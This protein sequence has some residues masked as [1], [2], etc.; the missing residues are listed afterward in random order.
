MVVESGETGV[1]SQV[2]VQDIQTGSVSEVRSGAIL[3]K[4]TDWTLIS[5][6]SSLLVIIQVISKSPTSSLL[7]AYSS[8]LSPSSPGEVASRVTA[9]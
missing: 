8:S 7:R 6:L 4:V 3:P 5:E 1:P 2:A 9:G